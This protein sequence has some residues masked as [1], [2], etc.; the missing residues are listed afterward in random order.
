MTVHGGYTRN[1]RDALAHLNAADPSSPDRFF[2]RNLPRTGLYDSA[3]DTGQ[4]ALTTEVMTSVPIYLHAGDVITNI[5]ARSG[6][7]AANTP[8][9]YW[10]ALYSNAATPA[11]LAQTADQTSTAW[12]AN[13][14]KT[15][16]LAAA[17]T[18][19]ESGIY[20]VGIMVKATAVPTLLGCVA[21]PAIVTGERNLSQSSGSSLAATAPAT[22]ATPTAKQFVPYVVLT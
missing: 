11:L 13:T 10:F 7:T 15:L 14:T 21:A 19:P 9:N 6:A 16:A 20:W 22:I 12:A 3:G 4:V 18:I 5:S 1:V 2:R 17:Q 8:T